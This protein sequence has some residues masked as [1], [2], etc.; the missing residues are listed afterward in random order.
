M[1]VTG[2]P[3]LILPTKHPR[4]N[5]ETKPIVELSTLFSNNWRGQNEANFQAG[6]WRAARL[7]PRIAPSVSDEDVG[8]AQ[9]IDVQGDWL[10]KR[11]WIGR[12][13]RAGFRYVF[14]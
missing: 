14:P 7:E 4:K 3:G 1:F 10:K 6:Q 12:S 9:V 11:G 5:Y 8:F 13:R 2:A